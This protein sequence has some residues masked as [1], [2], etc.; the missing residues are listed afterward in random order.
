MEG[1]V[2]LPLIIIGA[3]GGA[4]SVL[5]GENKPR[6]LREYLKAT[7]FVFA[8]A[9]VTNFLTPLAMHFIPSLVG[10]ESAVAFI[11][12]LFGVGV[13]KALFNVVKMLTTDFFGTIKKFKE[14]FIK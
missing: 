14:I 1:Y 2:K 11:V 3:I 10:L 6:T 7:S 9:I 13:V 8:G 4:L 12:G 5:F